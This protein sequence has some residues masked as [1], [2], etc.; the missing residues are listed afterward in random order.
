LSLSQSYMVVFDVK[1]TI[2][3]I[4]IVVIHVVSVVVCICKSCPCF[5]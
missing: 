5:S 2:G 3:R 1:M 4:F